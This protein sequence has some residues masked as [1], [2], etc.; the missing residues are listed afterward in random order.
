MLRT[1]QSRVEA[2]FFVGREDALA[3]RP[4]IEPH[5]V[6]QFKLSNDPRFV[7]KLRDVVGLYV[8]ALVRALSC[9][10]AVAA[11]RHPAKTE[12]P[13]RSILCWRMWLKILI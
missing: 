3:A 13:D 7:D 4:R 2:A 6:R 9:A 10:S 12:V 5:R 11:R 1:R 8:D